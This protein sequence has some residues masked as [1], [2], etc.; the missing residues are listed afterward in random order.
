MT[1]KRCFIYNITTEVLET[2]GKMGER[3][4]N[5]GGVRFDLKVYVFGGNGNYKASLKTAE[6][7]DTQRE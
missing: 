3:R 1:L 7:Y 5:H 2:I 4:V 6:L